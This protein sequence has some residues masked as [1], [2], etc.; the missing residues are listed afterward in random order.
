MTVTT[1]VARGAHPSPKAT[2]ARTPFSAWSRNLAL[3][4]LGLAAAVST[5][6]AETLLMPSRDART[7]A[8]VVVWG[9]TTQAMGAGLPCSLDFGDLSPAF[10]CT[11]V[12]RSYIAQAH[13]YANQGTY[14]VRLTVGLETTTTT[15]QVFNPAL[16]VG[17]VSGDNNR[18][19]GVNMAI[20]DGLRFLWTSQQNRAGNFPLGTTTSWNDVGFVDFA[21]TSLVV[22]AFENQGYKITANVAPTGIYE[23]YIVRRGLNRVIESLS[24]ETLGLTP[25]GNNPCVGV[26]AGTFA[27]CIGLR[28]PFDTGYTTAVAILS[29]AG[30]G[31]L[32]HVNT[33]VAGYTNGKTYGEI[34]QRLVNALAWGQNDADPSAG[35]FP[36]SVGRGGW[37][38]E[39]NNPCRADGSTIGWDVLALLDAAA[40]GATVPSWVISEFKELIDNGGILNTDGSFDYVADGDP[41]S[42]SDPGPQKAG[43][44]LQSLFLIGETTGARVNAVRENINSWWTG[45]SGIGSNSWAC[46][47]NPDFSFNPEANKSCAYSMFNNFKG[48]KLQ[49]ITTLPNVGRPA[50]PGAIPANDWYAD[51]QDWFVS[52][53][54]DPTTT[55]GGNWPMGFSCCASGSSITAAIAELILAPVALVAPDPILFSTVGLS[56]TSAIN[57]IG[58]SHTVTAFT[59]AANNAPVP[60]VTVDFRVLS[61]PNAGKTGT[62]TTGADGKTTFTYA[63]TGGPAG[64]TD[65]IQA[66]IGAA[67]SSNQVLK[68]WG[69]VCDLNNDLKVSPADLRQ[70]RTRLNTVSTGPTDPYD[71][72]RDGVVNVAD[73][74]YCQLRQTA[75]T[76]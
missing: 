72:N 61:G 1:A 58:T 44:G 4:S 53:Q 7:T 45:N 34:L 52:N 12:D 3:A 76:P 26:P 75:T 24:E 56:P 25:A 5:A 46:G 33:E 48:L 68:T 8:P 54:I 6:S 38:Y 49:G 73:L 63:D 64:G 67:L 62:G 21:E 19:L 37:D 32:A 41:N 13:T 66:F 16:L 29:L 50:G 15:I 14:T 57:P 43:I 23:K 74:R 2:R 27:D 65:T 22:L 69:M 9:V 17:G 59:Q 51:Y 70:L 40:A 60:G 39:F 31:A 42:L 11:G 18:S 30:S 36:A 35:C 47:S 20:Q 55:G 28:P 71:P 10:N